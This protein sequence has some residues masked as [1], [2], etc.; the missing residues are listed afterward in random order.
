MLCYLSNENY[1]LYTFFIYIE[2]PSIWDKI[3]STRKSLD[4][5][6]KTFGGTS[7]TQIRKEKD[8]LTSLTKV[9]TI[10]LPCRLT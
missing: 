4:T 3:Y 9:W 5:D 7:F 1:C 10:L 2:N 8:I 6:S